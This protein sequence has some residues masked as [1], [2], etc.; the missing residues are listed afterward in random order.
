M[1]TFDCCLHAVTISGYVLV[2]VHSSMGPEDMG[3]EEEDT[4]DDA[5]GLWGRARARLLF[6]GP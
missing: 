4:H 2:L 3:S 5:H 6:H 1:V